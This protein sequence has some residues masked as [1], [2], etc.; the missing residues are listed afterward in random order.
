MKAEEYKALLAV[1]FGDVETGELT[2]I[3]KIRIDRQQP[4]E[5]RRRQYLEKVGNP[6]LVRVGNMKV[7]VRFAGNGISMED[8]FENLLLSV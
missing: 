7:K 4:L 6:Y 2:D 5:E 1:D 8:A 3:S